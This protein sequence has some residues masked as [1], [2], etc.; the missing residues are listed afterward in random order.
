[1]TRSIRK[2]SEAKTTVQRSLRQV[3]SIED[4]IPVGDTGSEWSRRLDEAKLSADAGKWIEAAECL[5]ALAEE[6]DDFH[7]RV[8]EAREMLESWTEIG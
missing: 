5:S 2:E 1:M 8:E 7:S 3:K 6:L 4:R